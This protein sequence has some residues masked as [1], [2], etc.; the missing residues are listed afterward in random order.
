MLGTYIESLPEAPDCLYLHDIGVASH[1]AGKGV[2]LE[3]V[4][5]LKEF[6]RQKGYSVISLVAVMKSRPFWEK[7]GFEEIPLDPEKRQSLVEHYGSRA[8]YM[9]IDHAAK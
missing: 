1:M 8:C 7:H 4:T 5:K 3:V 2:G 9:T 6:A